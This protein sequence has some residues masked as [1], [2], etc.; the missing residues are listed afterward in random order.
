MRIAKTSQLP[1]GVTHACCR[2]REMNILKMVSK[3]SKVNMIS[4]RFE[5]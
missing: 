5:K 1:K 2:K 4:A 3:N